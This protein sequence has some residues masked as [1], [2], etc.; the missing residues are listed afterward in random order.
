[1]PPSPIAHGREFEL[2]GGPDA[3]LLLHGLTGSTFELYPIA[4]RLHAAGMR[5]LAPVMAGHGGTP[6]DLVGVPWTEWIAKAWRDLQRLEGARRTFVVGCSMGAL[7]ACALAHDHPERVEGLVLLAPAL[8]LQLLGK[9]A[10]LMGGLGALRGVVIP[11]GAGSDVRDD[12]M[13]LA[14][15]CMTGMPL[16]AVAELASLAEH[17]DRQLPGIPAPALVIA[18]AHDHTIAIGGAER[19]ARRIG[20]GPARLIVLRESWHLVGV[21]VERERVADETVRFLE[22]LP[23]PGA[24]GR[25]AARRGPRPP[26][27]RP[28]ESPPGTGG[29]SPKS[30]AKTD[31]RDKRKWR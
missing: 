27:H 26:R 24:A 2:R 10:A 15:P 17:V 21:D 14:N 11:K 20:S 23:V 3:V 7:V 1:M 8:E 16:G 6:A 5:C 12:E 9:L 19:L 18:G 28:R 31:H 13:R 4:E 25:A 29:E 22:A 30:K